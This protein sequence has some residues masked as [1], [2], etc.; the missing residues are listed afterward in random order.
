[1]GS[2]FKSCGL[3]TSCCLALSRGSQVLLHLC[4]LNGVWFTSALFACSWAAH[5][6]SL[7]Q[8]TCLCLSSLLGIFSISYLILSYGFKNP[9]SPRRLWNLYLLIL[10]CHLIFPF[11]LFRGLLILTDFSKWVPRKGNSS[12]SLPNLLFLLNFS[13]TR[14]PRHS[15]SRSNCYLFI[16]WKTKTQSSKL[17]TRHLGL[18]QL[19]G[20][21][22]CHSHLRFLFPLSYNPL[23][24]PT[25][26]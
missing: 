24:G 12:T 25:N 10:K 18:G 15:F 8:L 4:H 2:I 22:S 21:Q 26:S 14:F 19:L 11:R 17:C 1:M 20:V 6:T 16:H 23:L 5:L 13:T 9:C 3:S 7:T